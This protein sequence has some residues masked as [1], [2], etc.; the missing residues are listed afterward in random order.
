MISAIVLT[1]SFLVARVASLQGIVCGG[2]PE[3]DSLTD[4]VTILASS[5]Y[6]L[7][8]S[9]VFQDDQLICKLARLEVWIA[10]RR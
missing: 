5:I 2:S 9:K 3:C 7:P 4:D 8:D 1:L 10:F 6:T